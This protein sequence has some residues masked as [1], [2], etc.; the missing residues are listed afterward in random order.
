M[1]GD[2]LTVALGE[3][4]RS[5]VIQTKGQP[6][7]CIGRSASPQ[8]PLVAGHAGVPS[9]KTGS[10]PVSKPVTPQ[11]RHAVEHLLVQRETPWIFGRRI[12]GLGHSPRE[13]S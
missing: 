11:D 13:L 9:D 1:L 5:P 2:T 6:A 8:L 10:A 7:A 3:F 12:P 4:G